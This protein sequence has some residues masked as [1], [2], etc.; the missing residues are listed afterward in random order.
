[1][2]PPGRRHQGLPDPP[3]TNGAAGIIP[4]APHYFEVACQGWPRRRLS[5][6]VMS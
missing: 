1:M 4:A 2:L 5:V 3:P 6:A